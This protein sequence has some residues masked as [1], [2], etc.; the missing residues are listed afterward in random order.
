V[1][2]VVTVGPDDPRVQTARELF[3]EYQKELGLD[4][5]F[6]GFSEELASLPG[7]YGPPNGLLLL[8]CEGPEPIACGALRDL[9]DGV[10]EL[11]RIYVRP[12]ARR[13]G[14]ARSI[15]E[16]LLD[17]AR[18]NGYRTARLDTLRRLKGAIELYALLGFK[19]TEPYNYNPETDIVYMEASL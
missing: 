9:G 12:Q 3:L 17:F 1:T 10:C 13:R 16:R 6:Q 14:I 8:V 2:E 5:C 11:K 7:K 19:E 4:L 18:T 15:S